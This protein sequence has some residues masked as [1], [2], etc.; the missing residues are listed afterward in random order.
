MRVKGPEFRLCPM[1]RLRMR[2][3]LQESLVSETLENFNRRVLVLGWS[4]GS[5]P[6]K[7]IETRQSWVEISLIGPQLNGAE[8][9]E[10]MAI[11]EQMMIEYGAVLM[12]NE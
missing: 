12:E 4:I 10:L 6:K 7:I 5:Y 1:Q 2:T 11:M 3:N 9:T 8:E